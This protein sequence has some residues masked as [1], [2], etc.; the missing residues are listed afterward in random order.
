M[1][2]GSVTFFFFPSSSHLP[3][4]Y[5]HQRQQFLPP[6]PQPTVLQL[7]FIHLP[8]A[9]PHTVAPNLPSPATHYHTLHHTCR[10]VTLPLVVLVSSTCIFFLCYACPTTPSTYIRWFP[11]AGY[12]CY[13]CCWLITPQL[14]DLPRVSSLYALPGW[15]CSYL[16]PP[17]CLLPSGYMCIYTLRGSPHPLHRASLPHYTA[18]LPGFAF[19]SYDSCQQFYL[20]SVLRLI[21]FYVCGLVSLGLYLQRFTFTTLPRWLPYHHAY[22]AL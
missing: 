8:P 14:P 12:L 18:L 15:L 1:V 4:H 13:G 16:P 10:T 5:N 9:C 21:G 2:L 17:P 11:F 7:G 3:S 6:S 20:H 22:I 19:P